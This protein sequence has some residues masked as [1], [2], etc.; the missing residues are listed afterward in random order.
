MKSDPLPTFSRSQ[1]KQIFSKAKDS[2]PQVALSIN[3]AHAPAHGFEAGCIAKPQRRLRKKFAMA[4]CTLRYLDE[5]PGDVRNTDA[6]GANDGLKEV[7]GEIKTV[8]A[9]AGAAVSNDSRIRFAIVR[10]GDGLSAHSVHVGVASMK[11]RG[12]S[13]L[14]EQFLL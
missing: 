5:G 7:L 14:V 2:Q 3:N 13:V 8:G 10:D 6:G 9:A 12:R 1:K 11:T 4:K